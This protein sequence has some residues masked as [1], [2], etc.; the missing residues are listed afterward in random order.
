MA[1]QV[2]VLA[3]AQPADAA[4]AQ[5]LARLLARADRLPAGGSDSAAD[6]GDQ[7]LYGDLFG[8][9]PGQW[10][11]AALTRQT[12]AGDA[13]NH[14]WLR[15]D[16]AL[17]R[18]EPGSV[19]L[20][21]C[22]DLALGAGEVAQLLASLAPVFGEEGYELSAPHPHRWYL[23]PIAATADS[24]LPALPPPEQALGGDLFE[25]WPEDPLHRRWRVLFGQVQIALAAHPL[26]QARTA[27]GQAP[28]NGVWFWGAGRHPGTLPA[29]VD[30]VISTDPLL[31]AL[32]SAAG[33]QPHPL[34][35]APLPVGREPAAAAPVGNAGHTLLDLRHPDATHAG[36]DWLLQL[37][38]AGQFS[39]LQ[40]RSP[41]GRWHLR[42]WHRW[43]FWRR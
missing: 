41:S 6:G 31:G 19:R 12:D 15:A 13:G 21:R 9:P 18:V 25:L 11:A 23:R 43:R 1:G 33:I 8:L 7:G 24:D 30:E 3:P 29:S 4:Q 27:A 42:R 34:P 37:W 40:W 22:G 39:Q 5:A 10:P 38:Q 32:A 2:T 17:F 35:G 28:V 26:N 14:A 20:M 36:L 16:P